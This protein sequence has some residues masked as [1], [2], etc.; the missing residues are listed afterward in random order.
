[1]HEAGIINVKN[2]DFSSICIQRMKTSFP[3]LDY[4]VLDVINVAER[5][6]QDTFDIIIDKGCLDSVLNDNLWSVNVTK[7]KK[8]A[9][10]LLYGS[11]Q[12]DDNISEDSEHQLY[13]MASYGSGFDN[14]HRHSTHC[15]HKPSVQEEE[16]SEIDFEGWLHLGPNVKVVNDGYQG[17]KCCY[18]CNCDASRS[19]CGKK[20]PEKFRTLE[21]AHHPVAHEHQCNHGGCNTNRS[22]M[23]Q[24][25]RCNSNL[26]VCRTKHT[27]QQ[28]GYG[29]R[30]TDDVVYVSNKQHP[31]KILVQKPQTVIVR[32]ESRP[33]IVVQQ[34][35][36]N[37]IVKNDPPQPVYVQNCPPNVIVKNERPGR[38]SGPP[39]I[40]I[41]QTTM[42]RYH[43][44]VNNGMCHQYEQIEQNNHSFNRNHTNQQ[45][46]NQE[47]HY[48]KCGIQH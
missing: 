17:Q 45:Q 14:I 15:R 7:V 10:D 20:Y 26:G 32:N 43:N 47:Q 35:P 22:V 34:P 31:P 13:T 5:F 28:S 2:V 25:R 36:P 24:P 48:C 18:K 41:Q 42:H 4:E 1:M 19:C 27:K 44:S 11:S 8:K 38:P 3:Q 33:P 6:H 30:D 21:S 39:L 40:P 46:Y 23:N 37:V 12:Q 16:N 29:I 9:V